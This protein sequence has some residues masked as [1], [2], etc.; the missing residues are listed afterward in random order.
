MAGQICQTSIGQ[1]AYLELTPWT[2]DEWQFQD[3]DEPRTVAVFETTTVPAIW[4]Q[5][6][7]APD[8][9]AFSDR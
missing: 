9:D 1:L 8:V 7:D 6:T 4:S 2:H 5:R 3:K